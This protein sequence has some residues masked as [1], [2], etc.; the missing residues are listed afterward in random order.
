MYCSP[1]YFVVSQKL[2]GLL[3]IIIKSQ[4]PL[5]L[6]SDEK[7]ELASK[8]IYLL[9]LCVS[10]PHL[11]YLRPNFMFLKASKVI[12]GLAVKVNLLT[13]FTVNYFCSFI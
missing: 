6:N 11:L 12:P 13:N 2:A 5:R 7:V 9:Y 3:K 10:K 1:I 8:Q 4:L